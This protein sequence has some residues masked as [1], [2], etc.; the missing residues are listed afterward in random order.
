MSLP[1]SYYESFWPLA[2]GT[3]PDNRSEARSAGINYFTLLLDPKDVEVPYDSDVEISN[4]EPVV[5]DTYIASDG[6]LQTNAL[7]RNVVINSLQ[8]DKNNDLQV[9][10]RLFMSSDYVMVNQEAERF[11]VWQASTESRTPDIVAVDGQ[12]NIVD[13]FCVDSMSGSP[14]ASSSATASSTPSPENMGPP[15][16]GG[17][18]GGIVAE[19]ELEATLQVAWHKSQS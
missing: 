13:A 7:V 15:L 1:L 6:T 16:S 19:D 12:N 14:R 9:L 3:P 17:A 11:S 10:G 2:G 18:I 5:S 8:T 4:T